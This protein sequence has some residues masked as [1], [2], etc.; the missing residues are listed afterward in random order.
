MSFHCTVCGEMHDDLPDLGIDKPDPWWAVAPEERARRIK[1][2]SDTCVIDKEHYF[3][4]GV[5]QIPIHDH[6]APFGF[7]VWVSQKRENF[8]AYL[9]APQSA[10]I[11]PF[12]G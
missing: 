9:K 3:I 1:L 11:G 2:T 10:A 7:G 8:S 12:F 4:H 6:P 5:L